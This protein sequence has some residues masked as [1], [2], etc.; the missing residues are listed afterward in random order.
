VYI[1]RFWIA[2]VV[3]CLVN[4]LYMLITMKKHINFPTK[5]FQSMVTGLR[6]TSSQVSLAPRSGSIF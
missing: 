3:L 5:E 2:I 4:V 6:K 1:E